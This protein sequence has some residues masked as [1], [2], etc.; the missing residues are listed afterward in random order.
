MEATV[1]GTA[2]GPH[3]VPRWRR[4]SAGK[5]SSV[6]WSRLRRVWGRG[7]GARL[8]V[9]E[10]RTRSSR[11]AARSVLVAYRRCPRGPSERGGRCGRRRRRR[12]AA[13]DA[14]D[15]RRAGPAGSPTRRDEVHGPEARPPAGPPPTML[16]NGGPPRASAKASRTC[17][18]RGAP[19]ARVTSAP[20]ASR[21]S[22]VGVRSTPTA[23][24]SSRWCSA[25]TSTCRTPGTSSATS[26]R[27]RRVARHGAQKAEENCSSVARSPSSSARPLSAATSTRVGC[28]AAARRVS[29]LAALAPQPR[30]LRSHLSTSARRRRVPRK[31]PSAAAR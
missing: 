29:R 13:V 7:G 18:L 27:V 19:A 15:G 30:M 26:A 25:S 3:S 9:P 20:R 14:G 8:R 17:S 16:P 12:V 21:T 31:R 4:L 11:P 24:T 28:G 10:T 5:T 2:R 6:A 22:V 1:R 23:R